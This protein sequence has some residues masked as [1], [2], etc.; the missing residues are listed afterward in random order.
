[1]SELQDRQLIMCEA[2]PP[3]EC[4]LCEHELPQA[5]Q[6]ALMMINAEGEAVVCQGPCWLCAHCS[7]AYVEEPYFSRIASQFQYDP[8]ALVG[9]LD[10]SQIPED[11]QHL[12]LG[13]DPDQPIPL[14]E[15]TGV[16]SLGKA[17]LKMD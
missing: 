12:P 17:S 7:S 15:F 1:M 2:Q 13:E 16:Q 5:V 9:F 10:L 3:E 6:R 11:K 14:L 8:Y 4:V